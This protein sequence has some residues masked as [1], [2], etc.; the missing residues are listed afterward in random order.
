MGLILESPLPRPK[1]KHPESLRA[2][3]RSSPTMCPP[4]D[5]VSRGVRPAPQHPCSLQRCR[6][7]AP[8]S[9]AQ[10]QS[11]ATA[12]GWAATSPWGPSSASNAIQATP[13]RA[14][15]KSSASPFLGPWP[16]GMSQHQRVWVSP[17]QPG[18]G[19]EGGQQIPSE[20]HELCLPG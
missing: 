7:P 2:P 4:P 15:Q 20:T 16:S 10:C 5:P 12:G 6:E 11:P 14:P 18:L 1:G 19:G 9:A 17:G 8:R 13:C 3:P